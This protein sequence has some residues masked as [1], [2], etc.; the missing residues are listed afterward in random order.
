MTAPS[1]YDFLRTLLGAAEAGFFPGMLSYITTW[2]PASRR[3]RFTAYFMSAIAISGILSGPLAGL[4][5]HAMEGLL[6]LKGWQW[7]FLVGGLPSAA[8]GVVAYYALP[9]SPRTARW[10][11]PREMTIITAE[12]GGERKAK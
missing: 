1:H 12:I 5:M 11:T 6:G 4:T 9:D 7:L 3:G 2:I 10:L 8:M